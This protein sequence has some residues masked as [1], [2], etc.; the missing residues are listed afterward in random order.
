MLA[1]EA[2]VRAPRTGGRRNHLVRLTIWIFS[3]LQATSKIGDG[4]A[5]PQPPLLNFGWLEVDRDPAHRIYWEE[6]GN[7]A[8]EPVMFLHGGP[9]GACAPAM[10]RFFDP[11]RYRVILFD[12]RGCGKSEPNVASAGPAVAL[13]KNTTADL[14]GD[15]E[16]LREKLE[17]SGPMHVFGGIGAA[18]W[19]WPMRPSIRRMSRA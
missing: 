10:A 1:R 6:Y 16:K 15:I 19:R 8:G 13:S 18:R 7:P 4:W 11:H 2:R 12:Q 17:I 3:R 14:I 5:Y 9:G